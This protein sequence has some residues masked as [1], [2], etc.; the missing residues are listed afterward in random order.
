[1][2]D[3]E[4]RGVS[5]WLIGSVKTHGNGPM[6]VG[7]GAGNGEAPSAIAELAAGD[8][9]DELKPVTLAALLPVWLDTLRK[10][11]AQ[12]ERALVQATLVAHYPPITLA[13]KNGLI[14][15]P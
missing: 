9:K 8:G 7:F 15:G 6:P 12:G 5:R 3:G 2:Q 4:L 11:G 1:M 10:S 13:P 14:G